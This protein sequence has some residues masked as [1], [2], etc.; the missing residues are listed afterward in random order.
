MSF[1]WLRP[2]RSKLKNDI[3]D[4]AINQ[5]KAIRP[6]LMTIIACHSLLILFNNL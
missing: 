3:V 5:H 6:I 1:V 4:E 2:P